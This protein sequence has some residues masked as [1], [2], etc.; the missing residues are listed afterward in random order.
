VSGLLAALIF[1]Y[2]FSIGITNGAFLEY[3]TDPITQQ[4][5]TFPLFVDFQA[6][7]QLGPVFV[8]GGIRDDFTPLAWNDYDPLQNTYT[9]RVGLRFD[10]SPGLQLEAGFQHDCF[11]PQSSYSTVALLNGETLAIPRYE[12]SL[13][14]GYLTF[15][16]HVGGAK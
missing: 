5:I 11:H 8:G 7:V 15:R 2:A 9:F 13:D 14:T 3:T 6:D 1:N 12:G 16:G 4:A 10:L